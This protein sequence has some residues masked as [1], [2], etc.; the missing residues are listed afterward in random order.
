MHL[1]AVLEVEDA[2]VTDANSDLPDIKVSLHA[3]LDEVYLGPDNIPVPFNVI[4]V[5]DSGY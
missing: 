3:R 1:I 4:S 5:A 2:L